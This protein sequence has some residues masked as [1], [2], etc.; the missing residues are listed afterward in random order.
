MTRDRDYASAMKA[1]LER[2]GTEEDDRGGSRLAKRI[3]ASAL[4]VADIAEALT[5]QLKS[6]RR[7]IL[8][9]V[10][11]MTTL[12]RVQ[13]RGDAEGARIDSLHKRL[14]AV[15]AQLRKGGR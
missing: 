7:E 2:Y 15:E 1:A 14:C 11:R 5:D 10:F 3:P 9:H 12:L 13:Q 4:S 8:E 6:Q